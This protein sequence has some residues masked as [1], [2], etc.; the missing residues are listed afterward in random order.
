MA[1]IS[2][3]LQKLF[4][5]RAGR[6]SARVA[7]LTKIAKLAGDP[8]R[9]TLTLHLFVWCTLFQATSMLEH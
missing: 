8:A 5:S 7:F 6:D 3:G 2:S 9:V 4:R 1:S